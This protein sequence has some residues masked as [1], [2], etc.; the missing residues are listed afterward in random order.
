MIFIIFSLGLTFLITGLISPSFLSKIIRFKL[1]R[2]DVAI[3]FILIFIFLVGYTSAFEMPNKD[4]SWLNIS[5]VAFLIYILFK[6]NLIKK[7]AHVMN[8][9]VIGKL[10]NFLKEYKNEIA[11]NKVM[12]EEENKRL[13]ALEEIKLQNILEGKIEPIVISMNLGKDEKAYVQFNADRWVMVETVTQ[14]TKGKSKKSGGLIR[15]LVG[16]VLLGGVGA[17]IGTTTTGSKYSEVTTEKREQKLEVIDSGLLVFTNKRIIFQGKKNVKALTYQDII[18]TNFSNNGADI[19]FQYEGMLSGE[20]F[21]L[22]DSNY[23]YGK[24]YY[25]GIT[26]NLLIK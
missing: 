3:I 26:E 25:F 14:H 22:C 6:T 19:T 9:G 5:I 17:L 8:V 18:S 7:L 2:K 11:H 21:E 12:L 4:M 24:V 13:K 23:K 10:T 20:K 1:S 15:A 16:G